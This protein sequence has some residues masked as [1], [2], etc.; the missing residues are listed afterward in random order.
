MNRLGLV[1]SLFVISFTSYSQGIEKNS[2]Y[3]FNYKIG[4]SR[5]ILNSNQ[6]NKKGT[7]IVKSI[8]DVLKVGQQ[9]GNVF[10]IDP[11]YTAKMEEDGKIQINQSRNGLILQYNFTFGL[12]IPSAE[13]IKL[14]DQQGEVVK[15]FQLTTRSRA[16]A[17][18]L[19]SNHNPPIG[20]HGCEPS[21][22]GKKVCHEEHKCIF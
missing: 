6:L 11:S 13:T 9:V 1:L 22:E 14:L 21:D 15:N 17:L 7:L 2:L 4:S 18:A 20:P 19:C 12:N 10:I 16:V 8:D 3:Q 5:K